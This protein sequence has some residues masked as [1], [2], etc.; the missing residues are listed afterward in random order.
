MLCEAVR[1]L[2]HL[3]ILADCREI[4]VGDEYALFPEELQ[5]VAN[6]VA[7]VRR[8]SGAA[9]LVA[10]SLLNRVGQPSCALRKSSSG[11]PYWPEGFVGSLAHDDHLAVAAVARIE[12]IGG[13]G[14]DV[15]PAEPLPLELR[16]LVMNQQ[17]RR[18]LGTDLRL[19]RLIFVLKEAVY[20][21]VHPV[22]LIFLEHHDVEIDPSLLSARV[23]YGRI[24]ELRYC[25]MTHM[26]AIAFW[27]Q[28][29]AEAGCLLF[30]DETK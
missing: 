28:T 25:I 26:V 8:A 18:R 4:S 3:D 29:K 7:K 19:A 21:A 2:G 17:E 12:R 30:D 10:R 9:R 24:V 13:L 14:I 27:R 20:K 1:K 22:D 11:A 16:D 6:S 15:E 5:A 23:C